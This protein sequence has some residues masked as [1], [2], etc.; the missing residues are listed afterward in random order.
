M[1]KVQDWIAS[2][3]DGDKHVAYVGEGKSET[4]EF[5]LCGEG[6]EAYQNWSFHL[7]M[8]FDPE[9]ITTRESR[10]VVQTHSSSSQM[11][12]EAA[13]N[14]E[15]SVTKETYTVENE[16]VLNYSLTDI[17]PLEKRVG[18]DGIYLT[19][20]VLR[21]HT[22]LPGK[23]WATLRAVDGT[24]Q[25]IKKSAIMVFEVDAAICAIPAAR[26]SIS[27]MELIEARA[28]QAADEATYSADRAEAS[29]AQSLEN[30]YA[31][32]T[33]A[34]EAKKAQERSLEHSMKSEEVYH[35][36][37]DQVSA[38]AEHKWAALDAAQQA[39]ACV[40]QVEEQT[41]KVEEY[42]EQ[43]TDF[44]DAAEAANTEAANAAASAA[45]SAQGAANAVNKCSHY[46][47]QC[48][49]YADSAESVMQAVENGAYR[50][51][52]VRDMG[53]VGDGVT[54]DRA[55]ILAAFDKAK[56]MLPCEVYFPAGTYGISNGMYIEMPFGFGGLRVCGAGRDVTT[57]RYLDSYAENTNKIWYAIRLWF[58]AGADSKPIVP[59]TEE[60]WMHDVSFVGLT[61]YDPNPCANASHPSKGDSAKEET[62]GID[63]MYCKRVA[64]TDCQFITVG[65]EAINLDAC[66]D[67][68]V[69]N[70]H[71]VGC[72]G[73]GEGG[74]AIAICSGCV[75]VTVTGNTIN[76]SAPDE[77]LE[78]G[79]V[80]QKHSAGIEVESMVSPVRD[81]V[82]AN[83]TILNVQGSGIGMYA[84]SNG[85]A[86]YNVTIAH[87]VITGCNVG[88]EDSG[89]YPKVGVIISNNNVSDCRKLHGANGKGISLEGAHTDVVVRGNT[90]RNAEAVGIYVAAGAD[91]SVVIENNIIKDV[92]NGAVYL[93]GGEF[94]IRDC[95]MTN[96]GLDS[97]NP[98]TGAV[99]CYGTPI[100][101]VY[102]CR[103]TGVRQAKGIV[104][105]TEVEDTFIEM[106]NAD[107]VRI[108]D[109]MPLSGT[110]LR[111]LVNCQLDG[112]V[113][114]QQD[115]ALVQG[116]TMTCSS[117]YAYP[118]S[119]KANG[120]IV[121]NCHIDNAGTGRDA[122]CEASGYNHNLFTN[123]IVNRPITTVGAQS[124]SVNN[125]DTTVT[126]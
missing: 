17:A 112:G 124:L 123:N 105:A 23:L 125:I 106:V 76:S 70:N 43:V 13:V 56:T 82:I 72:P 113:A 20:T 66:H 48:A 110:L 24:A 90:I 19:W 6:W 22:M 53:A 96:T 75:G 103:L 47:V 98:G 59:A 97:T 126:A 92:G 117:A 65:D 69:A 50:R 31:C 15:E 51:I 80:I 118:I 25:Y 9:S 78:D 46:V 36:A 84:G 28:A 1:I 109:G 12:E 64:V 115:N 101:R 94:V 32:Q 16:E 61:V 89:N 83:N 4:R 41:A 57:I 86:V 67:A 91:D 87:N 49:S 27:E 44:A 68:V 54:D 58:G 10:Q 119:V 100:I 122:I 102:G 39:Q 63:I 42:C 74:G 45:L 99:Y 7:D 35:F 120:V 11:K 62:H 34:E 30:V 114:I 73:A 88:I 116:V 111:R 38:A 55:A 60:D 5:W 85:C 81:V 104:S 79:T 14:T 71:L 21:Q 107:G 8:A 77:V 52:N 2:I 3:P 121:A 26:P 33:Y 40:T 108:T 95:T 18:E 93:A 29:L 37:I